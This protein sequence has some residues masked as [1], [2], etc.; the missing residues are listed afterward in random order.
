MH[1][2]IILIYFVSAIHPG[3]HEVQQIMINSTP[4]GVKVSG[5]FVSQSSA[6]GILAIVYS[7]SEPNIYYLLVPRSFGDQ[8][9]STLFKC[10]PNGAYNV[11]LFSVEM[12]GHPFSRTATRVKSLFVGDGQGSHC[13]SN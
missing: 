12:N 13:L 8:R 7:L 6:Q 11:S 9:A 1:I 5:N 4:Q 10:I 2:L 3:T